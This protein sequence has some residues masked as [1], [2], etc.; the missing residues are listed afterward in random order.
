MTSLISTHLQTSSPQQIQDD[1]KRDAMLAQSGW[2]IIRFKDYQI[3]KQ[4]RSVVEKILYTIKQ[5]EAWLKEKYGDKEK[6]DSK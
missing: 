4:L 6:K 2:T 5:K 1:N 3:E